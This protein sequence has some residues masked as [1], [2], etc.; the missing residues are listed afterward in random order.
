DA[1]IYVSALR[2]GQAVVHTSRAGRKAYLFV[3]GGGLIV[4]GTPL[5]SR[6]QA[7]IADE[8]ELTLKAVEDAELIL[9]DLP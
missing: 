2:A 6:D 9:L 5:A 7:R 8:P 3:I 4:N 1:T